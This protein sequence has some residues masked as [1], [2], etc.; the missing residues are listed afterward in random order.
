MKKKL[1]LAGLLSVSFLTAACTDGDAA[2]G[3][4]AT[5]GISMPDKSLERWEKDGDNMVSHLES[6]GYSVDIQY[7]Q[8]QTQT[9]SEQIENMITKDVDA[10]IIAPID[11]G[12]LSDSVDQASNN[13]IPVIAYDRLIMNTENVNYY[14][15]FDLVTVGELQGQYIVEALDLE[16]SDETFNI[17][18]FGGAPD[19]NNARF[20]FEGAMNQLQPFMDEGKIIV[21]SGQTEFNAVA[22]EAWSASNAQTRM[23]NL[24]TG[25][26]TDNDVDAILAQN[27]A[28]A[29]GVVSSLV[30]M[31]YG[32]SNRPMPIIT[33]QDA[34]VASVNS[35]IEGN[36]TM[37]VFK[38]T[39]ALAEAAAAIVDSILKGEDPVVNDTESFDNNEIIVPTYL[40]DSIAVDADNYEEILIDSGYIDSSNIR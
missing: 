26:Y 33:G 12:T 37:T 34:E 29:Q 21:Q 35:I 13:E 3:E 31:G 22:T 23:D 27:D 20:F 7:A 8:G 16:N 17:E 9:Q 40:L 32:S 36:Q 14:T 6:M 5:V 1:L 19:D 28:I 11:G 15:T 25:F 24:L 18:L 38:D 4:N 39:S 2:T 30:S 10:L